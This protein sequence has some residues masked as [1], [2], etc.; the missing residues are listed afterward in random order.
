MKIYKIE[1]FEIYKNRLAY[2]QSEWETIRDECLKISIEEFYHYSNMLDVVDQ[3]LGWIVYPLYYKYRHLDFN[4]HAPKTCKILS[5]MDVVNAVFSLFLPNTETTL[6]SGNTPF[7]YRSHLG[8]SVPENCGFIVEDT[9]I[10]PTDGIIN[11]FPSEIKH[12]AWNKSSQNRFILLLDFL[13]PNIDESLL[14]KK[15]KDKNIK[16]YDKHS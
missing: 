15:N 3:D 11:M 13:K 14:F 5:N 6:H 12:I 4:R 8:L 16:I 1:N 2:I 10:T 7:T 9:D